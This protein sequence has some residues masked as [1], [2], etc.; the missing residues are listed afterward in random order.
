[1][2]Q[3]SKIINPDTGIVLLQFVQL[4][5][6]FLCNANHQRNIFLCRFVTQFLWCVLPCSDV[7]AV[8]A[9]AD[10]RAQTFVRYLSVFITTFLKNHLGMLESAGD[11]P[12]QSL[13]FSLQVLLRISQVDDTVIFK[14]CLEYWNHLVADLFNTQKVQAN[15]A[16]AL[17]LGQTAPAPP[18]RLQFYLQVLS[19]LRLVLISQMAKPEEVRFISNLSFVW[20]LHCITVLNCYGWMCIDL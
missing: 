8:Y 13:L 11:Q 1:M 7:A 9:K 10:N 4:I 18:P 12:R 5:Q 2:M 16:P 14:I 6:T 17:M 19:R 20:H 3:V 15:K